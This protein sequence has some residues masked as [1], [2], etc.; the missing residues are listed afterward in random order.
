MRRASS[1]WGTT[2]AFVVSG[3]NLNTEAFG[4][5]QGSSQNMIKPST[6]SRRSPPVSARCRTTP[7]SRSSSTHG[8]RPVHWRGPFRIYPCLCALPSRGNGAHISQRVRTA[9]GK[10][11]N[12]LCVRR[13]SNGIETGREGTYLGDFPAALHSLHAHTGTFDF[14][15]GTCLCRSFRIM[16][17][18]T[19]FVP[20]E[21]LV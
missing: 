3:L 12:H 9:D 16:S 4:F 7:R 8:D 19:E 6:T 17:K 18:H 15:A 1:E 21:Q 14:S 2:G 5:Y 11:S 13:N 10:T 20:N